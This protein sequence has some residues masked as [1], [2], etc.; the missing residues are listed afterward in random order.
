MFTA[1]AMTSPTV[2]RA[3]VDCRPMTI[4]AVWVS[5]MVSVGLNAVALVSEVYR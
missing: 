5:G 4:F 1:R 2:S 3:E